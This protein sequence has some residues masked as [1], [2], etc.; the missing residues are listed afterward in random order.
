LIGIF[1]F[2]CFVTAMVAA[3]CALIITGIRESDRE[4]KRREGE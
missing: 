3:A 2:G 1:I 4:L